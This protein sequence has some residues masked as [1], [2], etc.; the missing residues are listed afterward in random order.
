MTQTTLQSAPDLRT[1]FPRSPNDL[2]GDYILLGRILDKCRAVLAG[3]N[4]EYN[5]NCPLDQRFFGFTNIDA[6]AFKAQVAQGKS[7]VEMLEWVRQNSQPRT[8][9][10][11]LSWTYATRWAAP[12]EPAH[13]AYFEANRRQIAPDRPYIQYWFQLLDA[14]EGRY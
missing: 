4:G 6:E 8:P 12:T 5:F 2:L 10:E 7:D 13:Q 1:G 14:E 3:T 9:E 11:I